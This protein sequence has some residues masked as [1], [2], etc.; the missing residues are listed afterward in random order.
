M[1]S[2]LIKS[3]ILPAC[4]SC[5]NNF[6]QS[7]NSSGSDDKIIVEIPETMIAG[8]FN[9]TISDLSLSLFRSSCLILKIISFPN[10]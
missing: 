1:I 2:L 6:N 3:E 9:N 10:S 7:Q 8:D 4:F 5:S